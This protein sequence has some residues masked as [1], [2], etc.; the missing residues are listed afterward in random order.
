MSRVMKR[1][2]FWAIATP[3]I[4]A[5]LGK[6]AE[7]LEHRRGEDSKAAKGVRGVRK[8]VRAVR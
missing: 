4:I 6:V 7:E 5:L 8:V 3:V 1:W 2:L